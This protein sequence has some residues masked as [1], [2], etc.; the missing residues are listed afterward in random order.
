MLHAQELYTVVSI[1]YLI[2]VSQHHI[3]KVSET[4]FK[5]K[6]EEERI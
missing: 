4:W 6:K 1:M 3:K 5:K 2:F